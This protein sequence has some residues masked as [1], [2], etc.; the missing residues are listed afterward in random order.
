MAVTRYFFPTTLARLQ[1]SQKITKQFFSMNRMTINHAKI[2][3]CQKY[4]WGRMIINSR[5]ITLHTII[6]RDTA[7]SWKLNT[8]LG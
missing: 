8:L 4:K 3:M 7:R 5:V 2:K 6:I 1:S